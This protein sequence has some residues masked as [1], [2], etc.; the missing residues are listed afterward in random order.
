MV[1]GVRRIGLGQL[2]AITLDVIDGADMN[3]VRADDRGMFLDL[4]K[5]DHL[6]L[7]R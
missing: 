4:S 7:L 6:A 2:D 1:L 5:V 3:A